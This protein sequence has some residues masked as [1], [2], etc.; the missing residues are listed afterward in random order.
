MTAINILRAPDAVHMS[1]DTKGTIG[2]IGIA[3]VT[4]CVPVPHIHAA[5]A[6]RGHAQVLH[7]IA[8]EMSQHLSY[9]DM[10]GGIVRRLK[11][12]QAMRRVTPQWADL[13][14]TEFDAFFIGWGKDGPDAFAVFS[15]NK[16][17]FPAH[18]ILDIGIGIL[19][20]TV[21]HDA[22]QEIS[23]IADM[24]ARAIAALSLQASIRPDIVGGSMIETV[25]DR[26][27]IRTRSLGQFPSQEGS[28]RAKWPPRENVVLPAAFARHLG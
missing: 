16:H 10:K 6:T 15:H 28:Q 11:D 2:D 27:S 17:G 26:G 7:V 4:K 18:Q 22:L 21:P 8:G 3:Q 24:T 19:T 9:D 20:P 14:E 1:Y 5:V 12:T 23:N 25:V 13:L